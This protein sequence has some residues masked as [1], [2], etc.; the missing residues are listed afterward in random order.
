M[1]AP[2]IQQY[3]CNHR[4]EQKDEL[5]LGSKLLPSTIESVREIMC[6]T[7]ASA[8]AVA[9]GLRNKCGQCVTKQAMSNAAKTSN[10]SNEFKIED[11]RDMHARR[12]IL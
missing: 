4:K 11:L 12:C 6:Y 7:T 8:H 9:G 1:E 2:S 3:H 10:V 5:S